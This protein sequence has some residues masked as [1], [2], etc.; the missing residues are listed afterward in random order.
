MNSRA[1]D[2]LEFLSR[3]YPHS[4]IGLVMSQIIWVWISGDTVSRTH[5]HLTALMPP[6]ALYVT[7]TILLTY[8]SMTKF[9]SWDRDRL[10][11][12]YIKVIFIIIDQLWMVEWD[13]L[14]I[15]Q[16]ICV[17]YSSNGRFHQNLAFCVHNNFVLRFFYCI[18]CRTLLGS[19]SNYVVNNVPCPVT[20]VK[21]PGPL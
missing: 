20:V 16:S 13:I 19:V 6:L 14:C 8:A 18:S 3:L 7:T 11:S 5:L 10:Q 2:C 4:R 17:Y 9:V 21:L 15:H 1:Y 12:R